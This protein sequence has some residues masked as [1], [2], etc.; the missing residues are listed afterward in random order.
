MLCQVKCAF[1]EISFLRCSKK[2]RPKKIFQF[3]GKRLR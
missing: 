1:Y 3:A 2:Y